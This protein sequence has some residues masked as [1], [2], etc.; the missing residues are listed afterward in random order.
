[1]EAAVAGDP[2]GFLGSLAAGGRP[3]MTELYIG[4][5]LVHAVTA[6]ELVRSVLIT[7]P[8]RYDSGADRGRRPTEGDLTGRVATV[9]ERTRRLTEHWRPGAELDVNSAMARYEPVDRGPISCPSTITLLMQRF[10]PTTEPGRGCLAALVAATL[11]W[12]WHELASHPHALA[13]LHAEVDTVLAGRRVTATDVANL[14]YTRRV[15]S[16]VVRLHPVLLVMRTVVKPVRLGGIRL[17][18]GAELLLRPHSLHRDAELY[19]NPDAFDPDRW[20]ADRCAH[21]P[22]G[23]FVPFGCDDRGAFLWTELTV[24]VAT[25]AARWQL[26]PTL[27][28]VRPSIAVVERPDRLVM[29]SQQRGV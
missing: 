13:R 7:D 9:A 15:V 26:L 8:K 25:I 22:R 20:R 3:G 19:E 24:A 17:A 14:R 10:F 12:T 28:R 1:M 18:P 23:A 6:P 5:R 21:L 29:V 27:G 4:P 11:A 2:L 16:E